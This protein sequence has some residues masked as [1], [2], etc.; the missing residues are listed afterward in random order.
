MGTALICATVLFACIAVAAL[1]AWF[2]AVVH[3]TCCD[4]GGRLPAKLSPVLV[5]TK[6]LGDWACP[7]CGTLFDRGARPRDRVAPG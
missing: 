1:T 4:C 5:Q 2:A 3:K 7:K 6:E